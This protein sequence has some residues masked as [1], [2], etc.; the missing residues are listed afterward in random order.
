MRDLDLLRLERRVGLMLAPF[1]GGPGVA[2][3]VARDGALLLRR[4]FGQ[5]SI[6]GGV[7][8]A[9]DTVFRIASVSK[10]VTCAALWLLERDGKLSLQ[11]PVGRFL[12]H[13]PEAFRSLPLDLLARNAS[14]VWD[15]FEVA[16][17]GGADLS[18]PLGE[19]ALDGMIARATGFSFAPG[20]RF[21]YCNTGF[22]WLGQAIEHVTGEALAAFL[23]RRVFAPL[24]MTRT[25]H[26]PD[27]LAVVPGL[28][29]A[30]LS[31][32]RRAPHGFPVGGEGGL[33]STVEDLALWARGLSLGTLGPGLEAALS[34]PRPFT[35]GAMNAYALGL[36]VE[37]WRGLRLVSHGGLWPGFRT[38]FLRVP[39]KRITVMAIANGAAIDPLALGMEALEA[40]L[41]GEGALAPAPAATPREGW[42]GRWVCPEEGLSLDVEE[43]A[44]ARMHGVPFPLVPAPGGAWAA[45]RSAFPFTLRAAPGGLEATVDAGHRLRFVP[46]PGG[47]PPGLD[48]HW[49]CA[50]TG[51]EWRIAGEH[52]EVSGP[53]RAGVA[54][55]VEGLGHGLARLRLP[56]VL[57]EAWIDVAPRDGALQAQMGRARGLVLT[58]A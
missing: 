19:D 9:P 35:G 45:R 52:A 14:G 36:E 39:E 3:G 37:E 58:R 42:A 13:L 34:T 30:Y 44:A 31:D 28:A 56:S 38:A 50:E 18:L 17:M 15:M 29:T 47:L 5:A 33:V 21:L 7:P 54:A 23:E 26:V 20:A 12:P 27:P 6:E 51:A 4:A 57:G 10:H 11:D 24:G 48:G 55:R 16:R 41:E 46:A 2:L 53:L 32:E 1:A 43:G 40:A 49:R 8:L 25:R 22:R